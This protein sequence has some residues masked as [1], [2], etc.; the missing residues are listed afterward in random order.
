MSQRELKNERYHR[1]YKNLIKNQKYPAYL[2][3]KYRSDLEVTFHRS[4]KFSSYNQNLASKRDYFKWVTL[5]A[6]RV[7][8]RF[9]SDEIIEYNGFTIEW[10]LSN[11]TNLNDFSN[12]VHR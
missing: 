12:C 6:N 4:S 3:S 1:K 8:F 11:A 9:H 7:I 10:R 5:E 2:T